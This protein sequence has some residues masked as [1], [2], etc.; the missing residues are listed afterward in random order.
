MF[1]FFRRGEQFVRCELRS[2]PD[3]DGYELIIV[4]PDGRETVEYFDTEEGL[5]DRWSELQRQYLRLGWWGPHGR[6]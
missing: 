4:H 1:Y 2:A 3:A 5:T 6:E